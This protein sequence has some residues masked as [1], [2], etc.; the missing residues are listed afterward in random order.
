MNNNEL[1]L[2]IENKLYKPNLEE[3]LSYVNND[4]FTRLYEYIVKEYK[5]ICSVEYS[6]DKV[7]L[8]W[9]LKYKKASRTLVTVYPRKNYFY[10]L[11]IVGRKEKERVEALLPSLSL[12]FQNKY[13][14]TIECMNQRWMIFELGLDGQEEL[15]S[16]ILK[17]VKI[18]R[19]SK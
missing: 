14:N 7:L 1:V 17:I 2:D 6:K 10:L 18:R 19:E 8:G 9:N 13:N 3:V 16:D 5:P 12:A 15:Y 11:L 4:M